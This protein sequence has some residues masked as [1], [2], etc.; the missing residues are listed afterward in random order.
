MEI[1]YEDY[2]SLPGLD[3]ISAEGEWAIESVMPSFSFSEM[4]ADIT[5]G[6]SIVDAEAVFENL[7]R[8][9]AAQLYDAVKILAVIAAAAILGAVLEN[10]QSSFG[11]KSFDAAG[12]AGIGI[13]AGL[14]IKIFSESCTYAQSAAGDMTI[15][16]TALLPILVT[17]A[18]GGGMVLTGTLTHPVILAMCAVFANIFEKVLIPAAVAYMA[19]SV[20]DSLGTSVKLGALRDLIKKAYNFIVGIVM[21]LFTGMLSISGFAAGALDGVSAK[22]ARFALSTMVPF[23]GGSISDAMSAVASACMVIKNAVGIAGILAMAAL[24]AA[25]IL[26]IGAIVL[27]VRLTAAVC[28]P[29]ADGRTIKILTA[30]ADALSMINAAVISTAVMMVIAISIIIGVRA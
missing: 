19:V 20:L 8:L 16:M 10:L 17:M 21:T 13:I 23:V 25:P 18:A 1:N 6:K 22:G 7:V 27:A 26:R 9:F 4:V 30:I 14:G 3:I 28:E 11:K 29:V 24:C 2:V 5:K 15:I 12:L